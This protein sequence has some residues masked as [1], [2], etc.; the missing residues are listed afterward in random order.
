MDTGEALIWLCGSAVRREVPQK[1]I[2]SA[3]DADA[4]CELASKH[5]LSAITGM[6]LQKAGIGDPG[7]AKAISVAQYKSVIMDA[8]KEKIFR[9]MDALE[10]W[11][12]AL[13]GA[14]L[15]GYYPNTSMRECA[16]L[17]VLFDPQREE[18]VR[19]L[20]LSLGYECQSFGGGH[21]DVYAK[22]S[23]ISVEM[24]VALFGVEYGDY[25]NQYFGN[26]RERLLRGRGWECHFTP[27]DFYVYFIAHNH[28]HY[29]SDGVGVRALLDTYVFLDSQ[30]SK[31][32]WQY[33]DAQL[34]KI[35][36]SEFEREFRELSLKCFRTDGF[37]R[38]LLTEKERAILDYVLESGSHGLIENRVENGIR[39]AGGGFL[40]KAKYAWNRLF[41]PMDVV[42]HWFPFFYKHKILLPFL[43]LYRAYKGVTGNKKKISAEW[44]A[45]RR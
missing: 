9:R 41:L 10:I 12:V 21:H 39:A 5:M 31:L 15:K 22:A 8:E 23:G 38:D 4:L 44:K 2:A 45:F 28:S 17:D 3:I 34:E 13:K 26:V 6:S 16:D 11:H 43:P 25:L 42:E 36:L 19:E 18:E 32:N 27:E 37:S 14:E 30:A 1:E 7:F 40:G 24:H 29:A 20:M 33:V 35:G